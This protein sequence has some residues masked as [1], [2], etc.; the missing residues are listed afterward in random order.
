LHTSSKAQKKAFAFC[1]CLSF[2]V[3]SLLV[4]FIFCR[5]RI[6]FINT[7]LDSHDFLC[8]V[9]VKKKGEDNGELKIE[10]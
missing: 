10:N 7:S 2:I 9:F 5:T 6:F 1:K 8:G 3:L 4:E